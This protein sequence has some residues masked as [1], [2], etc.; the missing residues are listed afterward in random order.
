[1]IDLVINN[2]ISA[3]RATYVHPPLILGLSWSNQ[4]LVLITLGDP[5]HL[6]DQWQL[7]CDDRLGT[8]WVT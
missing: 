5:H 3:Q 6:D 8:L 2:L 7:K 4:S 1:M